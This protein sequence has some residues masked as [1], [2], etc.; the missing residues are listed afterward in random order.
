MSSVAGNQ[1]LGERH[2]IDSP[3]E[4][5]EGTNSADTMISS[6]LGEIRFLLS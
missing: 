2:G 3:S 6:E 1:K 5:P 4:R